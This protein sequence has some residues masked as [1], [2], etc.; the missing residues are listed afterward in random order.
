MREHVPADRVVFRTS[1]TGMLLEAIKAGLGIGILPCYLGDAEPDLVRLQSLAS[2]GQEMWILTHADLKRT[3][4]IRALMDHL[5]KEL[6]VRRD[7]I[8]GRMAAEVD[9]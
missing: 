2:L 7:L 3:P 8:E 1:H 6:T 5:S 9:D 4:R